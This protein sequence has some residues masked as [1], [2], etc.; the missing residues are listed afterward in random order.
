MAPGVEGAELIW[1]TNTH[2][3][4]TIIESVMA[5]GVEGA[6]LMSDQSRPCLKRYYWFSCFVVT[7]RQR[8]QFTQASRVHITN[9]TVEEPPRYDIA[10]TQKPMVTVT[11]VCLLST[12]DLPIDGRI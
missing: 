6:E 3:T 1:H 8:P 9:G 12:S 7:P 11:L 10:V 5:S 4:H 2:N